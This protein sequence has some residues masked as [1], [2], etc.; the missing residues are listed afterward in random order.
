MTDKEMAERSFFYKELTYKVCREERSYVDGFLDGLKAGRPQ[1]HNLREN[2][3]DL[4]EPY[5]S[6]INQNGR[7]VLYDYIH[8]V[9]RYDDANEY[10]CDTPIVWCEVPTYS[11]EVQNNLSRIS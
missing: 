5:M 8:K 2:P 9:W 3:N 1:W 10:I 4:P 6:V 11:E 7:N